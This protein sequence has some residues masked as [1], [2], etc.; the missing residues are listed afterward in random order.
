MRF[1]H[2]ILF[3]M[4]LLVALA[5]IASASTTWYVDGINGSNANNCK[6]LTSACKTIGHVIALVSSGDSIKLAAATYK[7]HLTIGI[8][9]KILGSGAMKTILDGGGSQNRVVT[10][11]SNTAHVAIS[12]VTISNGLSRSDGGGILNNGVLTLLRSTVTKNRAQLPCPPGQSCGIRGG[13]IFNAVGASLT[14][15]YSTVS[16]NSASITNCSV[17][18]CGTAGGGIFNGGTLVVYNSTISGNTTDVQAQGS[19]IYSGG[20]AIVR[21]STLSA[22]GAA[23]GAGIYGTANISNSI[24]SNGISSNCGGN[25]TS[26]GYNLSSDDSCNLTKTGDIINTDPL[27]GPLQYN[28]GPT[29]TMTLRA[30]SLAVDAGNPNGCRDGL[31]HLLTTDQRGMPRPDP[32]DTSGCDIGAFEKQSD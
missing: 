22:N 26:S 8:S 9:L 12:D 31:G 1:K 3:R 14:V 15:G 29:Q 24:L 27:L 7:E 17:F 25:V 6:S 11:S 30:G 16:A 32:E 21:S 5:P 2:Q 23:V 19:G 13:G 10:I 4:S 18:R 28:G 20:T